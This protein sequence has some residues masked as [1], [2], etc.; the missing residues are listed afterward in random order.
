MTETLSFGLE[1]KALSGRKFSGYGSVF[2]NRDLGND[3]VV[4]GAFAASLAEHKAAGTMPLMLWMHN[5]SEVP[6]LWLDMSEDDKG[7]AVEGE[8]LDTQL[9]RDVGTLL[10]RKAVRGLS[11]GYQ[12]ITK[13]YDRDG[14]RLLKQV[15]L[16]EVSIV[17]MAMNPLARVEALKARLSAAGEYVPTEREVE[18]RLRTAGFSKSVCQLMVGRLYDSDP[19]GTP[20]GLR[21]DAVSDGD[22][23]EAKAAIAALRALTD[24]VG[25]SAIRRGA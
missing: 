20:D 7:L 12:V 4:P 16:H 18:Q 22:D 19:G 23:A 8:I 21:W 10:A 15:A 17:S 3:V 5:A 1:I 14:N 9:G 24:K 11:I 13:D 25:A 6:G 2:G